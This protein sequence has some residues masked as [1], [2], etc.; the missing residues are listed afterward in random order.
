MFNVVDIKQSLFGLIGWGDFN[1]PKTLTP[2]NKESRSQRYFQD[3]H[4]SCTLSN[5]YYLMEKENATE[6]EFNEYLKRLQE[7]AILSSLNGIFNED[8][9]IE[10][11]LLFNRRSD[12][13]QSV[14][15]SG[16]KVGYRI[17]AVKNFSY[18]AV[19]KNI[20]LLF[21][22]DGDVNIKLW[23]SYAG[24]LWED[25]YNVT[26][27]IEKIININKTL[28]YSCKEYKGGFF[29]LCYDYDLTPVE[30]DCDFNKTYAFLAE[31]F[32]GAVLDDTVSLGT[33]KTYGLNAEICVYRD[34][35]EI[36]KLNEGTFTTLIGLQMAANCIEMVLNSKRSNQTE[37][38]TKEQQNRLYND[39]NVA[40]S[41]PEFPYTT[42]IK[43]QIAREIKR[44]KQNYL[45]K[46]QINTQTVCFT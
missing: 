40:F 24:L 3:F 15:V 18:C 5:I 42:G 45:P 9:L 31:P 11:T 8:I 25:T 33:G 41:S 16:K 32:E 39:L 23:H 20:S 4:N 10:Q 27:N 22:Q 29:F 34:F 19:I 44:I 30:Y 12:V 37:R 6:A 28:Y 14:N 2:E 46:Q 35:T 1:S 26:A 21:T 13:V 7:T 38:I 17:T 43:N 36:I